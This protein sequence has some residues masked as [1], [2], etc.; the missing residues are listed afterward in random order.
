MNKSGFTLME[1]IIVVSF[2]ALLAGVAF[3]R[4][5]DVQTRFAVRGAVTAFMSAYS[6]TRATAIRE[7][8]VA[9]LHIDASNDR[10]WIE[11]DTTLAG[12]G[13]RDT[14][15]FVVDVGGKGVTLSSTQSLLCFE[16][17]GMPSSATGCATTGATISF[18]YDN[19]GD[20]ILTTTLG[21]ILR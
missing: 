1:V 7:G 17:R 20:T 5:A 8:G 13:G 14:I 10:F 3:P 2:V 9:E 4:I 11:V 19:A 15:G 18:T 16:G 6:L 21:K 12:S